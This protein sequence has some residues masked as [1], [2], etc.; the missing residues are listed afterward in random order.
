[1]LARRIIQAILRWANKL[2]LHCRLKVGAPSIV[3]LLMTQIPSVWL[4]LFPTLI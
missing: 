1:M 3:S 4:S 2:D